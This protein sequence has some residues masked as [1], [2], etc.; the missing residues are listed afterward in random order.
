MVSK[1]GENKEK[2]DWLREELERIN[3]DNP[4][5]DTYW[6]VEEVTPGYNTGGYYDQDIPES[7]ETVADRFETEEDAFA[8]MNEHEADEG[9][10]LAVRKHTAREYTTKHWFSV[11][12]LK[13]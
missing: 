13:K 8:W 5:I 7:F 6:S 10:Y 11:R 9:K 2:K 1:K 12:M 4:V 3:K